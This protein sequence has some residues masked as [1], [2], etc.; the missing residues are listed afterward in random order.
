MPACQVLVEAFSGG[1]TSMPS[2][3]IGAAVNVAIGDETVM[4][5]PGKNLL[6]ALEEKGINIRSQ[7]RSGLCGRCRIKVVAGEY[8]CDANL[9]LRGEEIANG[10]ALACCTFATG[11]SIAIEIPQ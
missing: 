9:A 1:E 11:A 7:C 10:Y 4:I 3:G 2:P 6:T 8:R 5:D